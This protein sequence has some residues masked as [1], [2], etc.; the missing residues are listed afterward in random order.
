MFNY[1]FPAI[2]GIQA[3]SSYY[4]T[5]IPIKL[6]KKIFPLDYS[7]DVLPEYRAQ[8]KLNTNRIPDIRNYI[9]NNRDSYVFSSLAASIDG[10]FKFIPSTNNNL[11]GTLEVDM[12]ATFLI[13]D[14]QHRNA[15]L[16]AALNIDQS[17]GEETI[18]VVFF[19]DKGLKRSQQ[20]FTDLNKYA[21]KPSKSQN[22]FYDS[23]DELSILIKRIISENSF[24]KDYTDVEND[25]LGKYSAKLFTLNSLYN[26]TK[27]II[28]NKKIDDTTTDF[29]IKF[30]NLVVANIAEWQQLINKEITKKTLREEYI[31]TQNVVLY[32]FGKL[33][34]F[35]INNPS[36]KL[37]V[38]LP[39]L[40]KIN[41]L[42]TSSNWIG[43]AIVNGKIMINNNNI[44]LTYLKI[45]EC[46]GIALDEKEKI[47]E[48]QIEI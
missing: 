14:G 16:Q 3:N 2:K 42:R 1:S 13:N 36:Y 47:F 29:C 33:G 15:A 27:S 44:T 40:Q 4:T 31:V 37:D 6:L 11:I 25:T 32:A 39:K 22:T 5:M 48:N 10:S 46:I 43:R 21:I 34:G 20:M 19:E 24:L 23:N 26:A 12:D 18:S 38:Y 41:W 35:L 7:N 8:R 28:S 45:K 9:L 30:W 17:L